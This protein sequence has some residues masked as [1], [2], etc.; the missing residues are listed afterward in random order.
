MGQVELKNSKHENIDDWENLCELWAS[1]L[2]THLT[3]QRWIVA[4]DK[5]KNTLINL[6]LSQRYGLIAKESKEYRSIRDHD[7]LGAFKCRVFG[8]GIYLEIENKK[9]KIVLNLRRGMVI[10]SLTFSS[11]GGDVCIGTLKHGYLDSIL[12]GSDY[13]SGGFVIEI[14]ES[15]TKITDLNPVEPSFLIEDNGDLILRVKIDTHIGKITKYLKISNANEQIKIAYKMSKIKRY[16]SSARLGNLTLSP[17]FS[18]AFRG[19]SC[20][21]GGSDN[22]NFHVKGVIEQSKP[23]TSFVSSSRGFAATNGKLLLDCSKKGLIVSWNPEESSP[24]CFIDHKN[25]YT[26]VTFSICEVDE[27]SRESDCYSDFE[28]KLSPSN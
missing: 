27:T 28:L 8:D 20:K 16:V 7:Y 12:Q 2:R 11:H 23:A 1:D 18:G 22:T 26:R 10:D 6:G 14:P 5:I 17:A 9:I 21:T 24:L 25:G 15:K 3:D 13:Y 4:K 19:Y